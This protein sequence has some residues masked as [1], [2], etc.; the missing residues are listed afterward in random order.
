MRVLLLPPH[1]TWGKWRQGGPP[2]S[3]PSSSPHRAASSELVSRSVPSLPHAGISVAPA[4]SPRPPLP[5][6]CLSFFLYV[7]FYFFI[8]SP[9]SPHAF[10]GLPV[11]LGA[12]GGWGTP[13]SLSSAAL[14]LLLFILKP[15][16]LM[17]SR[18]RGC[19]GVRGSG[20]QG[21]ERVVA[22][23][24]L[25]SEANAACLSSVFPLMPPA[26]SPRS[27]QLPPL[28]RDLSAH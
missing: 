23:L 18:T 11:P 1:Q 9:P 3:Q 5:P 2:E 19:A 12:L 8:P 20:I 21:P 4:L 28:P 25:H 27:L 22:S 14:S 7:Y 10:L 24:A 26:P 15:P 6:S 17:P 16:T 13:A